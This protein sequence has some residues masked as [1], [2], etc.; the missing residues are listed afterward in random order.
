MQGDWKSG[1]NPAKQSVGSVN[2]GYL[3]G[4]SL[5]TDKQN[6]MNKMHI[7]FLR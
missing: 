7:D 6:L 5:T 1:L 3:T 2:L 4:P